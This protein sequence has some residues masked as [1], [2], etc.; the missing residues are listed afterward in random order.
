MST[1]YEMLAETHDIMLGVAEEIL[2]SS[3]V[4]QEIMAQA[5]TVRT[6]QIGLLEGDFLVGKPTDS[7]G[8]VNL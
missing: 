6:I 2:A 7:K 1:A 4:R 8:M 3:S 5:S